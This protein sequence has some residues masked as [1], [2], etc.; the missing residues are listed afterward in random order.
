MYL[1]WLYDCA[2]RFRASYDMHCSFSSLTN[3]SAT[4]AVWWMTSSNGKSS[5]FRR[6]SHFG[7]G[8]NAFRHSAWNTALHSSHYFNDNGTTNQIK[9]NQM[10]ILIEDSIYTNLEN[11]LLCINREHLI[12]WDVSARTHSFYLVCGV[13]VEWVKNFIALAY[14]T[15]ETFLTT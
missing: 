11:I 4:S 8:C 2:E 1:I 7:H 6:R 15:N 10:Y 5:R 14:F 9:S 12:L 13:N 3:S